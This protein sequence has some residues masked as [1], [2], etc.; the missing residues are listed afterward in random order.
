MKKSQLS[1]NTII[2]AAIVLVVLVVLWSIFKGRM[3]AFSTGLEAQSGPEARKKA[4]AEVLSGGKTPGE[5]CNTACGQGGGT[6]KT[7]AQCTAEGKKKPSIF[8][9]TGDS[10]KTCC[11]NA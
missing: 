10:L 1:L 11:C 6:L 5:R 4:L 3:G 8:T 9:G 7:T 2:I